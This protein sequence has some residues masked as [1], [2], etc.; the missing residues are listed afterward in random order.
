[1]KALLLSKSKQQ[2]ISHHNTC[3]GN[4]AGS[5]AP[6]FQILKDHLRE[7]ANSW[8][9]TKG[10]AG[11]GREKLQGYACKVTEPTEN[12]HPRVVGIQGWLWAHLKQV[13]NPT[14]ATFHRR[15]TEV[16]LQFFGKLRCRNC[17]TTFAFLQCGRCFFFIK[18]CAATNKKAAL[19]H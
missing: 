7:K 4:Q 2:T 9:R 11:C 12:G 3:G 15:K 8:V 13:L 1:M 16:A 18:S 14:P 6:G 17:N 5:L 10:Q 19:Q